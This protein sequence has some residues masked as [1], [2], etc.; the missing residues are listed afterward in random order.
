MSVRV[1]RIR[2][3]WRAGSV[4]ACIAETAMPNAM[5][6]QKLSSALPIIKRD[7]DRRKR[8]RQMHADQQPATVGSIREYAAEQ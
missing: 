6:S 4:T 8:D 3:D 1:T 2:I 5:T 7:C